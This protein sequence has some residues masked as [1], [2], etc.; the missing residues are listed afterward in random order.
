MENKFLST[1]SKLVGGGGHTA[2]ASV[3]QKDTPS[4]IAY[5]SAMRIFRDLSPDEMKMVESSTVMT[6]AH[7]GKL[8]YQPGETGEVL[9]LL[10]NGAVHLY[11]LSAEG[12]KFIVQTVGP[13]TS[14][15]RWQRLGRICTTCSPKRRRIV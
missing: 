15:A 8:I 4:K 1:L 12:R 7:K 6:T 2:T 3:K 10:K 11:R 13:M 5:L 9:F 14:S